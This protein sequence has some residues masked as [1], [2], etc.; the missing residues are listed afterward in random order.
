MNQNPQVVAIIRSINDQIGPPKPYTGQLSIEFDTSVILQELAC[1][2]L[3]TNKQQMFVKVS[4]I[5]KKFVSLINKFYFAMHGEKAARLSDQDIS[6]SKQHVLFNLPIDATGT[7]IV[8]NQDMI[9]RCMRSTS[10]I[11]SQTI[12]AIIFTMSQFVQQHS[13]A[14]AQCKNTKKCATKLNLLLQSLKKI[15]DDEHEQSHKYMNQSSL[16]YSDLTDNERKMKHRKR[17]SV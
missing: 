10:N 7:Q 15:L 11:I 14:K 3:V 8:V 1:L 6:L 16:A 9:D 4:N 13:Q 17:R 2:Y 5:L 12:N